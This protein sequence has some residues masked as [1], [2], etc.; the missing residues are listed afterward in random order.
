MPRLGKDVAG[1]GGKGK[2]R[3][4]N[5]WAHEG[6]HHAGKGQECRV[7]EQGAEMGSGPYSASWPRPRSRLPLVQSGQDDQ[8]GGWN[9]C[10]QHATQPFGVCCLQPGACKVGERRSGSFPGRGARCGEVERPATGTPL[11]LKPHLSACFHP[12]T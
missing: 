4:K 3:G 9:D 2:E 11:G 8:L 6:S 7:S 1:V 5:K 12:E 10:P